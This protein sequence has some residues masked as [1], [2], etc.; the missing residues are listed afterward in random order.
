MDGEPVY[1][2]KIT[3]VTIYNIIFNRHQYSQ[4]FLIIYPTDLFKN[5]IMFYKVQNN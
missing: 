5:F 4:Q 1:S 3:L 2:M